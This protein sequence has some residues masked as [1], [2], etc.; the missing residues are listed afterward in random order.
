MLVARQAGRDNNQE[1]FWY[2][3]FKR[4][5]LN[6]TFHLLHEEAV[7]TRPSCSG[8]SQIYLTNLLCC[9]APQPLSKPFCNRLSARRSE[10][11]LGEEFRSGD[12]VARC[13]LKQALLLAV[14]PPKFSLQAMRRRSAV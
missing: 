5:R 1:E 7:P 9:L 2:E 10:R 4:D 8:S 13:S 12:D 14:L 6:R 3:G 11:I